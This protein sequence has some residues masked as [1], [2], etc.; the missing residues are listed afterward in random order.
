[1]ALTQVRVNVGG[2][3]ITLTYN[4]ATGRYE[5]KVA[6]VPPGSDIDTAPLLAAGCTIIPQ[7]T[8]IHQPGGYYSLTAEAANQSGEKASISGT[9]LASLRLVVRETAAPVLTLVSPPEGWLTVSSPAFVFLAQDEAGG[10]GIDLDSAQ[11]SIDGL[12]VPCTLT[13]DGEGYRLTFSGSGLSEGPHTVTVSI[14]DRDGNRTTASAAYQIDTIPPA[15][16][17]DKP[18]LRHVVDEDTVTVAGEAWDSA[19]A[20]TVTVGGRQVEVAEGQFS[21]A[22]P[23]EVG[24]NSIQVTARDA[25]GW[26]T[27]ETVYMIRLI[28]DRA[29][30]DQGLLLELVRRPVWE[31]TAQ[32]QT[33][34]NTAIQRGG[35]NAEDINR[36]GAAVR[37]LSAELERRGYFPVPVPPKTD[38]TAKDAPTV[39]QMEDYLSNVEHIRDAQGVELPE[40]PETMR[41]LTGGGAN[42]IERALVEADAVFPRYEIWTAGE[43]T[44]GGV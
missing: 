28:T 33:W 19:S 42:Q 39:P 23:L 14:S 4:Q 7:G 32:E 37:Y 15:L 5:H 3:W 18:Y 10:S 6:F 35:Y 11:A 1:M 20:V 22:W 27:S 26:E 34:Y 21:I 17:V 2:E 41:Q 40:I 31:W 25:A 24:E 44:S 12:S 8:S 29:P 30:A 43:L 36:V 13:Q 9:Q 38:W 16:R